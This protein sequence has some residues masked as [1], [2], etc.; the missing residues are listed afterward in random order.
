[1]ALFSEDDR[2]R[3]EA[4]V[5]AVEAG[6]ASEIVVASVER[7][8]SYAGHRMLHAG[9]LA[10]LLASLTHHLFPQLDADAVL[11]LQLP[12]WALGWLVLGTPAVLRRLV[13]DAVR[14]QAVQERAA[15]MFTERGVFDTRDHSGVLILLSELEHKVVILGDRGIHAR[16]QLEGWQHHIQHI[17]AATAAGRPAD[18]VCEVL[19]EL[20]AILAEAF[21]RRADDTNELSDQMTTEPR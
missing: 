11:W 4:K 13:P 10:A 5:Q 16:V 15:R 19:D 2:R 12:L 8:A 9:L 18:G 6:S 7:S 1:M 17:V 21:P 3:I 20:G 14:D